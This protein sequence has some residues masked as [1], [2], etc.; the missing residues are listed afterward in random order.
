MDVCD[1]FLKPFDVIH[2]WTFFIVPLLFAEAV[3]YVSRD[4]SKDRHVVNIDVSNN[5]NKGD[6]NNEEGTIQE[7]PDAVDSNTTEADNV[8]SNRNVMKNETSTLG[9]VHGA[10]GYFYLN[11]LGIFSAMICLGTTIF[12][13][14]T[15]ALGVNTFAV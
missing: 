9:E 12:I 10:T 7:L 13:Y 3:I 2:V 1:Y 14:V 11:L 8:C 6:C 4:K 15:S 5:D